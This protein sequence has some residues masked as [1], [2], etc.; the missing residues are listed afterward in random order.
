MFLGLRGLRGCN[1]ERR[2]SVFST[3]YLDVSLVLYSSLP[4]LLLDDL[5]H[6]S[7]FH[8]RMQKDNV[9][10]MGMCKFKTIEKNYIYFY[11]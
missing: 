10:R 2:W 7:I 11:I 8:Q 6:T 1:H 9:H 4:K 3:L 5:R